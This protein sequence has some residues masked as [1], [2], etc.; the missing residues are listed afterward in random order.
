MGKKKLLFWNFAQPLFINPSS[1]C[2]QD[3]EFNTGVSPD[4]RVIKASERGTL[5]NE[6]R[7][8]S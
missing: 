5:S 8:V 2:L 6:F 1:S 4:S 3:F 7:S